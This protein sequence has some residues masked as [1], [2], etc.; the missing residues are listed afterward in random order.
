MIHIMNVARQ[1]KSK[2]VNQL[3]VLLQTIYCHLIQ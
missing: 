2:K 1:L 3:Q